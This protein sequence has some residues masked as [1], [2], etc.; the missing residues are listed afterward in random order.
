MSPCIDWKAGSEV[1]SV[2]TVLVTEKRTS[3]GND[4][5]KFIPPAWNTNR[6]LWLA[7]ERW[8]VVLNWPRAVRVGQKEEAF[9]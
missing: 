1:S 7:S 9:Q 4:G 2:N 6:D 5:R 8:Q 3:A